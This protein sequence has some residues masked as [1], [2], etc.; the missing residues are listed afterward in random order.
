MMIEAERS[1]VH[2]LD[3]NALSLL[4]STCMVSSND[5]HVFASTALDSCGTV[6][7]EGNDNVTFINK[8][9]KAQNPGD[10]ITRTDDVEVEFS[11]SYRKKD[12]VSSDFKAHKLATLFME[13]G[14][15]KFSFQFEFFHSRH[16]DIRVDPSSYPIEVRLTE[17]IFMEIKSTSSLKNT[18]L[19]VESCKATPEDN[20]NSQIFYSIIDNGC[21]M[22]RTVQEFPSQSNEFRF[23]MQAFKFIG[24]HD[25]VY[26]SCSV[27]LCLAT[28]PNTRCAQGCIRQNGVSKRSVAGQTARHDI[29]QGPMRLKRSPDDEGARGASAAS[30]NINL[31][32]LAETLLAAVALVCGV[33]FYKIKKSSDG[34]KRL[35]LSET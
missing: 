3:G 10:I 14:F 29:M 19:F 32:I 17:M 1:L 27:M 18:V 21:A 30:V 7:Q 25:E 31:N 12:I 9:V 23:G 33:V 13:E 28:D 16:Y 35:P 4:D 34:Y 6:L 8:I 11:C 15:G 22:D 26:I 2:G 20:P 5:T 24:V